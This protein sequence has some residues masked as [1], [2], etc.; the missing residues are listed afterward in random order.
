MPGA[1]CNLPPAMARQQPRA[2]GFMHR[3]VHVGFKS[4]FDGTDGGHLSGCCTLEKRG[5][6]WLFFVNRQ[7]VM[8]APAT[9]RGFKRMG[10]RSPPLRAS[11]ANV[12]GAC[13]T[14]RCDR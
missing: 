4:P 2:R 1:R 9:S 8:A 6:A 13:L 10:S 12:Q 11:L 3:V 7:I 14:L 5:N